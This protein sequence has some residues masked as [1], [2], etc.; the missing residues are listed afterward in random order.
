MY[1]VGPGS[2]V[3]HR[4]LVNHICNLLVLTGGISCHS[5]FK[6]QK[7]AKQSRSSGLWVVV[8]SGLYPPFRSNYPLDCFVG[9]KCWRGCGG[10]EALALCLCERAGCTPTLE[11]DSSHLVNRSGWADSTYPPRVLLLALSSPERSGWFLTESKFTEH[12][13]HLLKHS[14]A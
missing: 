14:Q 2:P 7:Q 11:S 4:K 9:T 3:F 10:P 5:N 1:Q 6:R 8:T 12:K 13:I